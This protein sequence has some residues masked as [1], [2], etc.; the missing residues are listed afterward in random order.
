MLVFGLLQ[1]D[2]RLSW[3]PWFLPATILRLSPKS[4]LID[5]SMEGKYKA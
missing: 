1:V 3:H 2:V 5:V 4:R